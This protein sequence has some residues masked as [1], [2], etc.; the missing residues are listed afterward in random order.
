MST[1]KPTNCTSELHDYKLY[2]ANSYEK[3]IPHQNCLSDLPDIMRS[4][5]VIALKHPVALRMMTY[6]L[7]NSHT[8]NSWYQTY[9]FLSIG[10]NHYNDYEEQRAMYRVETD[11]SEYWTVNHF[12]VRPVHQILQNTIQKLITIRLSWSNY[13]LWSPRTDYW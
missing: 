9:A 1:H 7:H 3:C 8:S 12:K 4:C 5:L 10:R 13:S 2:E 11:S 6:G